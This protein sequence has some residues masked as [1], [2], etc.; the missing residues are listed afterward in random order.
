MPVSHPH[1]VAQAGRGSADRQPSGEEPQ[2]A[3]EASTSGLLR[4][5][6]RAEALKAEDYETL[7]ELVHPGGA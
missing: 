1:R 4:T 3:S 2:P 6:A 5:A 7:G